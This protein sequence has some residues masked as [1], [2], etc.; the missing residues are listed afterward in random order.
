MRSRSDHV[1]PAHRHHEYLP[2]RRAETSVTRRRSVD[3]I[4]TIVSN[5]DRPRDR[6]LLRNPDEPKHRVRGSACGDAR[7]SSV[8][9]RLPARRRPS[10]TGLAANARSR[11][12][13]RAVNDRIAE[14][15]GQWTKTGVGL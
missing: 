4:L 1:G 5:P 13:L 2:V 7:G 12:V 11:L 10:N 3:P 15:A 14:L 8:G 9:A 6:L